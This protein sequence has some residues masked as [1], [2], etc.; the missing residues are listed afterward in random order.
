MPIEIR[1]LIIRVSIGENNKK[2]GIDIKELADLK[3][4]I[5]KECMEKIMLRIDNLSDR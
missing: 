4:K 5:V 3:N 1:E 2:A